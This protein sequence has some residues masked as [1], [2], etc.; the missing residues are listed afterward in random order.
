MEEN[1]N[2]PISPNANT[3]GAKAELIDLKAVV[4]RLWQKKLRLLIVV[5]AAFAV[6]CIII[7]PVP[8][9]YT[10][11]LELAPE[12]GIPNSGGGGL[13]D[14]A[15]SMGI[16]VGGSII[17]DAIS[18]DLYPE[19]MKS[20][21]FVVNLINC[22]VATADGTI[23]TTYYDYLK[24]HRKYSPWS[25]MMGA[26]QSIFQKKES[27]ASSG[28]H[29]LDPFRLTK[30]ESGVFGLIKENIK[31]SVDKKTNVITIV[32]VDQDPLVAA[33]MADSARVQLQ[34]FITRYRT[35]K[36][37]V[38]LEHYKKLTAQAKAEYERARQGY[39]YFSDANTDVVLQSIRSKQEDLENDMQLKFNNYSAM[40]GQL[41]LAEAK[42][43]ER[44][45]AFTILTSASVPLKPSGPKRMMFVVG[46][47]IVAFFV[48]G[49]YYIRG[50]IL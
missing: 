4:T 41:Q 24:N 5:V 40:R 44:T 47:V 6:S 50:L 33:T 20:N 39:G 9:Y 17:S 42:V 19:L 23:K 37:R 11:S 22:K 28:K 13:A 2:A 1:N 34:D 29:K 32:V 3:Q 46:M 12:L 35:S 7:L 27:V 49:V 48:A 31:C 14:I 45:P 25:K 18:P 38:D 36:A 26:V 43:Q 8:R 21:D 15:S 16:N 10:S 30:P